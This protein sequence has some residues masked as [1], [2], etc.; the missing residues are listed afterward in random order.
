MM[1]VFWIKLIMTQTIFAKIIKGETPCDKV[2]ETADVLAFH[3]INPV[4]KVHILVIPKKLNYANFDQFIANASVDEI[5][6]F[7]QAVNKV[8]EIAGIKAS[9]FRLITN[10]GVDARQEVEHF[11]VHIIGGEELCN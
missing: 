9:G 5:A 2:Y 4:A 1:Q 6:S 8:A 11:H 7:W 3:D 10:N